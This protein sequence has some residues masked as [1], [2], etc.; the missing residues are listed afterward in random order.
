VTDNTIQ[1]NGVDTVTGEG[2][3]IEVG[4]GSYVAADIQGNTFGGN[5]EEDVVTSSFLSAGDT[6]DSVDTSGNLTFD[7]VYL[8]D[9]AQMDM[10]FQ[11]NSGNQI[12]PSDAGAVYTNLDPLKAQFFGPI[13]VQNRD[14][15]FFQVENGPFLNNP[16][17]TFINFGVTQDIQEAFTAGNYNLRAAADPAFPNIGFAPFLP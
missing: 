3:R 13:G 10:R 7:Y 8:D 15:S 12:A 17:N 14:V 4:T 2:L 1:N 6:F 9:T 5:L 11:N 16:N